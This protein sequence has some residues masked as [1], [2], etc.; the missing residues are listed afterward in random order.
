MLWLLF[1]VLRLLHAQSWFVEIQFTIWTH[2]NGC[3]INKH[4][5][6]ECFF[7]SQTVKGIVHSFL[8]VWFADQLTILR[9]MSCP[10]ILSSDFTEVRSGYFHIKC[11]F[12]LATPTSRTKFV[13]L[14]HLK[15]YETLVDSFHLS[16]GLDIPRSVV[17]TP[18][19]GV[20]FQK[21][22]NCNTGCW[23]RM[24]FFQ[25]SLDALTGETFWFIL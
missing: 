13:V 6:F 17:N 3:F 16:P 1:L 9:S 5:I 2:F 10:T 8:P 11:L 22:P 7:S 19:F 25:Y 15:V 21:F 12:Q 24:L 20:S 14:I 18:G 4:H 23:Y